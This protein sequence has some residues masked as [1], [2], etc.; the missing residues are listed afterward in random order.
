[1]IVCYSTIP[2]YASLRN[3]STGTW[4]GEILA[5]KIAKHAHEMHLEDILKQVR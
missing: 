4:F 1:M 3:T 5:H 2:G